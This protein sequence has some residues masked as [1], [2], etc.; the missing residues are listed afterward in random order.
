MT[1]QL[2]QEF[3]VHNRAEWRERLDI[4]GA[5]FD[6]LVA[7]RVLR[8]LPGEALFRMEFVGVAMTTRGSIKVTPRVLGPEAYSFATLLQL[9]RRYFLRSA[10]RRPYETASE[11]LHHEDDRVTREFDA[12]LALLSWYHEH[13]LYRH[14][15]KILIAGGGRPDWQRTFARSPVLHCDNGVFYDRPVGGRRGAYP[16]IICSLQLYF[17]DQLCK[18]YGFAP[19]PSLEAG[20]LWSLPLQVD[21]ADERGRATL[22]HALHIER[23]TVFRSDKLRLLDLL[24]ALLEVSGQSSEPKGIRL[25]GTTAFFR[26]WEDACRHYFSSNNLSKLDD[27]AQPQWHLRDAEGSWQS[28]A[29]GHQQPDIALRKGDVRVVLDAKYYFPFPKSRPGWADIVKQLYYRDCLPEESGEVVNAFLLPGT[30]EACFAFAGYV[31]VEASGARSYP[32]IEAWLLNSQNVLDC[33]LAG[34]SL[35]LCGLGEFLRIRDGMCENLVHSPVSI[36][37]ERNEDFPTRA[38]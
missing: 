23:R 22:V 31:S 25:Y 37:T 14:E 7:A 3:D 32:P 21:P 9:M 4:T 11:E 8:P 34:D 20:M 12:F 1:L 17:L 18:R 6:T 33:Y 30:T 27:L 16:T 2:S 38:A 35:E 26:V 15:R 24:L 29:G 36:S 19:P 13:G 5:E 28:D 10:E